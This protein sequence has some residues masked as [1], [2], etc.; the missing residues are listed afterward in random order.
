[1]LIFYYYSMRLLVTVEV[2]RLLVTVLEITL[3]YTASCFK[4]KECKGPDLLQ[5]NILYLFNKQSMSQYLLTC[6]FLCCSGR[7]TIQHI[8]QVDRI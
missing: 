5:V 8:K 1:M 6:C 3:E 4:L 7:N 2:W